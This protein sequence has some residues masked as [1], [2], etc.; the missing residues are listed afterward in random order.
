MVDINECINYGQENQNNASIN[1][2]RNERE[3]KSEEN[4]SGGAFIDIWQPFTERKGG[5]FRLKRKFFFWKDKGKKR[6]KRMKIKKRI[7]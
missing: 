5:G 1:D 7:K 2:F 6:K 4:I 3:R